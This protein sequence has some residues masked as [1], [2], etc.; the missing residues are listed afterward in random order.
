MKYLAILLPIILLFSGCLI[1]PEDE[2]ADREPVTI[3]TNGLFIL[4]AGNSQESRPA[5]ATYYH[6]PTNDIVPDIFQRANN[7]NFMGFDFN[8]ITYYDDRIYLVATNTGKVEVVEADGFQSQG[9]E[10]GFERPR[11]LLPVGNDK[12]YISQWGRDGLSGS[13]TVMELSTLTKLKNIT[14]RNG[15]ERMVQNGSFVYLTHTGGFLLDSV[16]SKIDINTD[17][18]IKTIEVGKAPNSI[19]VDING[20]IWVLSQGLLSNDPAF[21]IQGELTKIVNDQVVARIPVNTG[22]RNLVINPDRD[23][24][25]FTMSDRV[26]SHSINDLQLNTAVPFVTRSFASLSIDPI[27]G[28]LICGDAQDF[29]RNGNVVIYSPAGNLIEEFPAGVYPVDFAWR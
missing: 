19:Q 27:V 22:A 21:N 29:I 9:N 17:K 10:I 18:V 8:G 16:I 12:A 7:E 25:F 11:Y 1:T 2:E 24:L 28:N 3:Y 26:Y 5:T 23:R 20:A 13:V 14:T 6:R 4:N 15:A